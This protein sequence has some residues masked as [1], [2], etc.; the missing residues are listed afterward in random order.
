ML[1]EVFNKLKDFEEHH[2]VIFALVVVF[3]VVCFSWGIEKILEYI[4]PEKALY[5]YIFVMLFG[6]L[7]LWLSKYV[8]LQ[9]M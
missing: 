6:L 4:F 2:Q 7:L 1:V 9:V 5:N 8:V 3:A